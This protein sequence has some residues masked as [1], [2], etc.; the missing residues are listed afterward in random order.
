MNLLFKTKVYAFDVDE[1]LEISN[2]PIKIDHLIELKDQGH[3]VGICGNMQVFCRIPNWHKIISFL[4]QSFLTKDH[5]LYGLKINIPAEEFI[6]VGNRLGVTGASD[7]E[8]AAQRAGW[9]FIL[10]RDFANGMR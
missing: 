1:T 3:I 10:E 2:G 6:M 7:D 4:G 8:G 5:F 9:R